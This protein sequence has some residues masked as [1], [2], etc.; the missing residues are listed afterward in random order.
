MLLY[1]SGFGATTASGA[2]PNLPS[3]TVA[4]L[5]AFVMY[6]GISA[7]G[8]YQLNVAIPA[9]APSGDLTLSCTY[10]GNRTQAG[11]VLAIQ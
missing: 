2:L 9:G 10:D 4:G 3:V 6:A 7:P 5:P 1:G 11:V 8:L